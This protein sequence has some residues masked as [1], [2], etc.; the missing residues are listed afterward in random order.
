MAAG[1]LRDPELL[2]KRAE[3]FIDINPVDL[4]AYHTALH[5]RWQLA[6][7]ARQQGDLNSARQ[8]AEGMLAISQRLEERIQMSDMTAKW[9]GAK[10]SFDDTVQNL[11]QQAE[12]LLQQ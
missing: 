5:T 7:A 2:T 8:Q 1:Y 4:N 3:D 6:E 11:I 10:L 12:K 9:G